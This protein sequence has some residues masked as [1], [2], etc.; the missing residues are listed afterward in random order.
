MV[1]KHVFCLFVSALF[2]SV[3]NAQNGPWPSAPSF[4]P[5]YPSRKVTVLNGTWAF[6][7]SLPNTDATTVPY[8]ELSFN[9]TVQ[10]PSCFD[11]AP[12]AIKGPRT[13]V[14][15]K[16]SHA[17]TPGTS[18]LARF[19]A[20]NFYA[21]VFVDGNLLGNHTAGPYTPFSMVLPECGSSGS[22]EIAIVV[23]NVFDKIMSPTAT[24]GDFYF[25][26]GIIRPI[27]I[28]ELPKAS[29]FIDRIEPNTVDVENGLIDI[30]VA[31]RG[32]PPASVMLTLSFN[33][34]AAGPAV[35]APVVNGV[36]TLTKVAV[37]DAKPWSLG[38]G[39]L[40]VLTVTDS[41]TLDALTIRS[42]L[43]I[44]GTT[45]AAGGLNGQSRITINGEIVKLKGFNRHQM[46]PD[47]GAAVTLE[48]E[49]ID[50]GIVK[51][52]NANYV[53][54]GHYP[55]SQ[56]WL[57][58]MD[59]NGI[60]FW[61]EG[62]GPGVSSADINSTYF[63]QNQVDAVT[64]MVQTSFHHPSVI[65]HGFFNEG[66][67]NDVHACSGYETLSQTIKG[68]VGTPQKA[69][70]TWAS[71]KKT[72]DKCFNAADVV[73][74]NDY[75]G[76]YSDAGDVSD[77]ARAW[78]NSANWVLANYPDKPFTVSETGGGGIYEWV[79]ASLPF[80]SVFWSTTYQMN[81]VSADANFIVND[82]RFSALSIWLLVDFKVDDESCGQCDYI[83]TPAV[84][85]GNL[86]VPWDCAFIRTDCGRP[87]GENHKGAVDWWRR[88]KVEYDVIAKI[89]A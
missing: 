39:N 18:A 51:G 11:I 8:S 37:P 33:G 66:P 68:I 76:W 21:R 65:L 3:A 45:T 1:T 67:S 78:N 28:S 71:D 19:Y 62:L 42:G 14:Y 88:K 34:N 86:S 49:V 25:Y 84:K 61:E 5:H 58:L 40:Y 56:S 27:I 46:W 44:V 81:L 85:A 6:G 72:S 55:Q 74:F 79:N 26:S 4:Y 80:P 64:Q 35:S 77:C 15:Y 2:V 10:V 31:L 13:T 69:L 30:N 16:S 17:C 32:Q 89:Y 52:V 29:Y 7:W 50:L 59:E 60:A 36:A 75:P 87:N 9:T 54:A 47:T 57:D 70:V 23:N 24:G 82:N 83:Q 38:N 20:I 43:R 48:Q 22:R 41:T 63:M 53:R 12:L 73:S